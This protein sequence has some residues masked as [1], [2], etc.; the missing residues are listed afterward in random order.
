M[1]TVPSQTAAKLGAAAELFAE[2]GVDQTKIDDIAAATGIPKAT[3]YYYF[4]GKEEI[5]AFL[6]RD[7]L[8]RVSDEVAIAVQSDRPGAVRLGEV[9][10][11]QLRVMAEQPAVCRAL[12]GELGR[13]GR[14]PEIAA[15]IH[16]AY[17][18]PVQ[19]LLA[20]GVADGSLRQVPDPGSVAMALFGAVTISALSYLVTD[21]PLDEERIGSAVITTL[22]D[23]LRPR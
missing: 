9:I 1:R 4:A 14:I 3:L 8:N 15:V 19:A 10:R 6:F 5:L 23:G 20:E 11:A 18:Q 7:V 12:V 13:A 22:L 17:Y 16:A 21:Q 2:H